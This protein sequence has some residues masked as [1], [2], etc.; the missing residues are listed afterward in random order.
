MGAVATRGAIASLPAKSQA[1]DSLRVLVAV[2]VASAVVPR[3]GVVLRMA[4][5]AVLPDPEATVVM[6][7]VLAIVFFAPSLRL[8][9]SQYVAAARSSLSLLFLLPRRLT[10]GVTRLKRMSPARHVLGRRAFVGY[11]LFVTAFIHSTTFRTPVDSSTSI[12]VW[13]ALS[14]RS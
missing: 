12:L 13:L 9:T 8:W 2:T 7:T 6:R 11:T 1:Q 3:T 4:T 5:P 10:R 14:Q